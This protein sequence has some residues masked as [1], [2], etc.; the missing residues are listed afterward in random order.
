MVDAPGSNPGAHYGRAGSTPAE[1][2]SWCRASVTELEDVP[3]SDSGAH[4]RAC[5]FNPCR[6]Y[7]T[8][9]VVGEIAY[10]SWLLPLR[11]GFESR[12]AHTYD[13]RR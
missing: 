10:H 4:D 9:R 5:R 1:R 11:S 2:T 6:T 7:A 3:D 12:A 8:Q 13:T